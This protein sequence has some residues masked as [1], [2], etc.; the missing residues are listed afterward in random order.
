MVHRCTHMLT[1]TCMQD[2]ARAVRELVFYDALFSPQQPGQPRLHAPYPSPDNLA[3]AGTQPEPREEDVEG[4]KCFV[5]RYCEPAVRVGQGILSLSSPKESPARPAPTVTLRLP[6]YD[7]APRSAIAA[8]YRAL[9]ANGQGRLGSLAALQPLAAM[10]HICQAPHRWHIAVQGARADRHGGPVPHVQQT[11][12]HGLQG[13]RA[14][15]GSRSI[16]TNTLVWL[17]MCQIPAQGSA[18]A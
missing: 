3:P 4:L 16:M 13:V 14:G 18:D 11:M 9:H 1:C 8:M 5:A 6:V 10:L 15:L 2:G 7:P 12:C 17:G